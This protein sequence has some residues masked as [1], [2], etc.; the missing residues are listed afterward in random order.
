MKIRIILKV[1]AIKFFML[2][3]RL[4]SDEGHSKLLYL[5]MFGHFP[6]LKNP[7]T[8][9][10]YI[11]AA[12]IKDEKLAYD[13][14]T[15]KYAV[16]E[17]VSE[18]VG[19]K[20]LNTVL[21]IYDS[22]DDIDFDSLPR[23]FALKATHGSAYNIIVKDKD[24]LNKKAAK[25]K[26]DKWLKENF[27]YKDREKNYKNIKPR[28]MCDKYLEPE[29]EELEEYKLFCFKGKVGFISHN[30]MINGKRY[31]NIFDREWN[32]LPVR[33]GYGGFVGDKKPDNGDELIFVAEKLAEPFEFVRADLYNV[34][35]K[36]IF[37]ELTFHSGGGLIPFEPKEYDRE[38]GKLLGL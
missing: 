22:F 26:F 24:L 20:Y 31:S 38:Y 30:K 6:D 32:K 18:K 37:S 34:D 19:D 1:I 9:N 28:I 3:P 15:D 2:F 23:S 25:A 36:I 29:D 13:I 16:R 5:I 10:E 12:K 27:Y 17:Y 11:C 14:Y 4:I 21:G 8:M 33:Y 35:G 7:K